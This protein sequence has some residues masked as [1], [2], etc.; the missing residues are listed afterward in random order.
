MSPLDLITA[1]ARL[2]LAVAG[3]TAGVAID[4]LK[5]A[6]GLL[7][8]DEPEPA[9]PPPQPEGTGNGTP[10]R[11]VTS[12]PV[13]RPAPPPPAAEPPV[14]PERVEEEHVDEGTVLVAEVAEPGAEDGAGAELEVE[15][16][17]DG[18]DRMNADE[19]ADRLSTATREEVAAVQL[20]EA[21][22]RSRD[23]V[24]EAA[25]KRLRELTPPPSG[26]A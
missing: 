9:P 5:G 1:P 12:E 16:P 26:T 15:E 18:Y 2:A 8:R 7:E 24:L 13:P 10:A 3:R 19:I 11:P 25:E 6:R 4:A 21:V 20:Y 14:E 22:N 23:T 17:W